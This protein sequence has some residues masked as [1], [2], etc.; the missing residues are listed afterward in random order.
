MLFFPPRNVFKHVHSFIHLLNTELL[1]EL[2][3]FRSF[4]FL[5]LT[6]AAFFLS[7]IVRFNRKTMN[8]K[9]NKQ[10]IGWNHFQ[11][12]VLLTLRCCWIDEHEKSTHVLLIFFI[13][14]A[15]IS[16]KKKYKISLFAFFTCNF[17]LPMLILCS[18]K[19]L[20]IDAHTHTSTK[21]N[22][23][24]TILPLRCHWTT[25]EWLKMSIEQ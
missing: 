18:N 6:C 8:K 13:Y 9:T 5:L 3:F 2:R 21:A 15:F 23:N 12:L 16:S 20:E 17:F 22:T 1:I 10:K 4:L 11:C 14:F 19:K 7:Y 24:K 25:N